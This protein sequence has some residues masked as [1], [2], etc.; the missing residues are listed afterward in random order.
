MG[1][2]SSEVGQRFLRDPGVLG[3]QT[4]QSK[5]I[6]TIPEH[7]RIPPAFTKPRHL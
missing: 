2:A 3:D 1:V 6:Q 5:H 7:T 4:T